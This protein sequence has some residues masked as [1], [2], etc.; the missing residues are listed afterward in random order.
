VYGRQRRFR[1]KQLQCR[2]AVSGPQSPVHVFVVELASD[3]EPWFLVTTALDLTAA[4]A[5]EVF[6]A[7]L[8]QED[9]F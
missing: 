3:Q 1:D 5:V 8:R 6:T 2:W 7:R 4:Q 9:A